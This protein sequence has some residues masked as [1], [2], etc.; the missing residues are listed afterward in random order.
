MNSH[1]DIN[2]L[3]KDIG[4]R[5]ACKNVGKY[6]AEL[7]KSLGIKLKLGC[8]KYEFIWSKDFQWYTDASDAKDSILY[9]FRRQKSKMFSV[10]DREI[11]GHYRL[12]FTFKF[13][14]ENAV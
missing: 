14:P 3:L 4:I 13:H 8:Q 9:Y 7:E 2:Q 12:S 11:S 10:K 1:M 6:V 5:H